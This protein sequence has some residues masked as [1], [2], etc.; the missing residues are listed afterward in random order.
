MREGRTGSGTGEWFRALRRGGGGGGS[1]SSLDSWS[2]LEVEGRGR[3]FVVAFGAAFDGRGGGGGG[4]SS[5][6]SSELL[7]RRREC[8]MAS[9]AAAA[10][11]ER[12]LEEGGGL[13]GCGRAIAACWSVQHGIFF[14]YTTAL[15][16]GYRAF[17]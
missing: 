1:E 5:S 2:I 15:N 9:A 13:M 8:A 3:F 12:V 10:L 6:S 17:F 4:M 11:R 14:S 16:T 7:S